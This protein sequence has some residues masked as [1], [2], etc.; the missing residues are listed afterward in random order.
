M[1]E[2]ERLIERVIEQER[3]RQRE[4]IG[5]SDGGRGRG[6]ECWG[7]YTTQYT[8]LLCNNKLFAYSLQDIAINSSLFVIFL[9]NDTLSN[10]PLLS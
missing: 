2:K 6:G 10:M 1:M 5:D 7:Y 9:A 3:K 4:T 8:F